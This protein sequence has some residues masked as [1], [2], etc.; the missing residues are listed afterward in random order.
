M[1]FPRGTYLEKPW[2]TAHAL[3][4]LII[5][6]SLRIVPVVKKDFT[7]N[8]HLNPWRWHDS[9]VTWNDKLSE[10][11][12]NDKATDFCSPFYTF[13]TRCQACHWGYHVG[14]R[15]WFGS[16]YEVVY[17]LWLQ[18]ISRFVSSICPQPRAR[19]LALKWEVAKQQ[20]LF[21]FISK[22]FNFSLLLSSTSR[23]PTSQSCAPQT[24]LK[25]GISQS[26]IVEDEYL[27][28]I[29][30]DCTKTPSTYSPNYP[31]RS[32]FYHHY[33][34]IIW[35]ADLHRKLIPTNHESQI[36][37]LHPFWNGFRV[38]GY[39]LIAV[40]GNTPNLFAKHNF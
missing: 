23:S 33:P 6:Q 36:A 39:M 20:K 34:R 35:M 7:V 22:Q 21:F 30:D 17:R 15:T 18:T 5:H 27:N 31:I 29:H 28:Q 24:L 19:L 13:W 37:G 40:I 14:P 4:L 2:E 9:V 3:L 10:E 8:L 25:V 38:W 12:R 32:V 11:H 1:L 26:V 16:V